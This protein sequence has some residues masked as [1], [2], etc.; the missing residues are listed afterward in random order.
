MTPTMR[1]HCGACAGLMV[2][3]RAS[4][5]EFWFVCLDCGCETDHRGAADIAAED[6]VWV[7]VKPRRPA[8]AGAA[9]PPALQE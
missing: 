2:L 4:D 5:T 1:A 3:C 7:P 8:G 6:A 9:R